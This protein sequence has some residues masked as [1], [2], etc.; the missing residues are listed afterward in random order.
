M[1]LLF[2]LPELSVRGTIELSKQK[3]PAI[4]NGGYD[5]VDVRDVANGIISAIDN[6]KIGECYIL[7]NRYVTIKEIAQE[8]YKYINAKKVPIVLPISLVKI[9]ASIFETYYNIKREVPLFTK[10]SLYTLQSKSNFSHEKAT[11][12]LG[13]TT[14]N[15]SETIAD[16]IKWFVDSHRI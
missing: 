14:R 4:V 13:Y 5:F 8:I 11:N 16:T 9:I 6:G 3:L 15:L 2:N 10:Y 12:E 1:Q 7:S